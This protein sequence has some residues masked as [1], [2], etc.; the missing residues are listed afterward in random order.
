MK[1]Y[2]T[3]TMVSPSTFVI[4]RDLLASEPAVRRGRTDLVPVNNDM[5]DAQTFT[6]GDIELWRG[7]IEQLSP[8]E[9]PAS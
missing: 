1:T 2:K 6:D 9:A 4:Y 3:Y 5:P 7:L 8:E